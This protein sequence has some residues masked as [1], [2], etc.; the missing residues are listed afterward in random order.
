MH[1]VGENL[2]ES[3]RPSVKSDAESGA[4]VKKGPKSRKGT[5]VGSHSR[6][7]HNVFTHSPEDPNRAVC[8]RTQ[9]TR[10]RCKTKT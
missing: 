9:K 10:A 3:R 7:S 8:R 4:L 1:D 6:G 5:I 2:L